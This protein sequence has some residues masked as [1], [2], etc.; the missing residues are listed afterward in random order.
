MDWLRLVGGRLESRYRYSATMVY[1]TFPW[2]DLTDEQRKHIESL[3]EE[4]RLAREDTP[5]WTMA[6][7]YDPDDMP[8]ALREAHRNLDAAIEGLYSKKPFES[9]AE[10]QAYLLARYGELAQKAKEAA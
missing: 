9:Q 8:V 7:M 4:I 1:N 2:P 6:E 10:R 5:E 3:G